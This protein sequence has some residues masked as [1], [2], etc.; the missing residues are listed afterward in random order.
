M[1]GTEQ[2]TYSLPSEQADYIDRLV[3]TGTYATGSDVIRAGLRALQEKDAAID[4]WLREEVVPV[5]IAMQADPNRAIPA[6][7]VFDEIRAL[8][9]RRLDDA[10]RAA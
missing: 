7:Q 10:G 8:H 6:E 4:R 2:R 3:A 1:A 5:A 9:A